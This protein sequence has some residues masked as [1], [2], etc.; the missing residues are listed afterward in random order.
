MQGSPGG[1]G[2]GYPAEAGSFSPGG[3]AGS[4]GKKTPELFLERAFCG[5]LGAQSKWHGAGPEEVA[6]ADRDRDH[7]E[8]RRRPG[9]LCLADKRP[10]RKERGELGAI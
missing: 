5:P 10:S 1:E 7:V 9:R 2:L 4:L 6:G 3:T 8:A